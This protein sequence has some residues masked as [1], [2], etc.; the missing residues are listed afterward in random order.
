MGGDVPAPD[1][2]IDTFGYD[3]G[4]FALFTIGLGMMFT[5]ALLGSLLTIAAPVLALYLRGRVEE[6]TRAKAKAQAA[7]ALREAA[8]RVAPKLDEMIDE[9]ANNLDGWVVAAGKELHREM[10]DVLQRARAEL[11]EATP[12]V[13]RTT[14]E[15]DA[16]D[17]AL[18]ET[19]QQLESLRTSLWG[20][21]DEVLAED[22]PGGDGALR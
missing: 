1:V 16:L 22:C 11:G 10:I 8:A 13:S 5:N 21:T 15:C 17:K 18:D 20:A 7:T 14:A 19:R 2:N 3:V 12:D 4:V 9:F 6:E